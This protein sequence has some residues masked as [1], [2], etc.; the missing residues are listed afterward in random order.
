MTYSIVARDPGTGELGVA[1]QTHQ[2]AVGAI[3]PWVK[4]GVGAVATQSFANINFGPQLLAL[5]ETGL[6]AQSAL[7]A[8]IHAD[9]MPGRRQVAVISANGQ[10]AT[11]TGDNC[12]PFAGQRT[13]ENYSVQANMML[14][15]RVPSAMAAAFESSHGPLAV[16]LMRTLEAAQAEGG[17]IRGSQSA[18]V[19]VRAPGPLTPTWDLR[20]DNDPQPLAKL[21]ELVRIRLAGQLVTPP[22]GPS[23][24]IAAFLLAYEEANELAGSDEQTFWFAV[25]GLSPLG[26]L[27]RAVALLEPLFA[28]APQ[29]KDLLFRLEMPEAEPLKPRFTR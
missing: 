21:E 13:G 12:I 11:H 22:T 16:R 24:D 8:V 9:T 20:I 19:L 3:V 28:R 14:T 5:L 4:A 2:P 23:P 27:D 17:D 15:D 1:V 18:A 26:E 29:W 25:R 6:D 7:N 10:T